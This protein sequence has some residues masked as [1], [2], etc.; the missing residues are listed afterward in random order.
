[1]SVYVKIDSDMVYL[2]K[3]CYDLHV[4]KGAQQNRFTSD[5]AAFSKKSSHLKIALISKRSEPQEWD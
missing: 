3:Q 4:D 2:P 5:F 1:M